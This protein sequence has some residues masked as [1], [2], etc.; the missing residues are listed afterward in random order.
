MP[1]STYKNRRS[2]CQGYADLTAVVCR[3]V[4]IPARVVSGYALELLSNTH[5]II[6]K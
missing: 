6:R 4:E 1:Y 5:R 2:V 3:A